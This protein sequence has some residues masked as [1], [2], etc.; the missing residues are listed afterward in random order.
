[1]MVLHIVSKDKGLLEEISDF[2]LKERLIANAMIS[3]AVEYK[4]LDKAGKIEL[5]KEYQC[6]AISKS[7]LFSTIND[8]LRDKYHNNTPLLYCEPIILIDSQ[9]TEELVAMLKK[10]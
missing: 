2:L 4:A 7:L 1:M 8:V 3:D 9:Q 6:Q 5:S 10:V